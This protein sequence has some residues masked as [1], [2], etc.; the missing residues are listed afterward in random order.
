MPEAFMRT[1]ALILCFALVPLTLSACANIPGWNIGVP[2]QI[3]GRD[4]LD[5]QYAEFSK[6]AEVVRATRNQIIVRFHEESLFD[7]DQ[8]SLRP[9]AHLNLSQ[10]AQILI[11]YPGFLVVVAGHTDN[12]GQESHN[13]WIT[14]KRAYAVADF[15][16]AEGLD[17]ERIQVIGYGEAKPITT[18]ITAQG[19]QRNRRIELHIIR[20]PS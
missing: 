4:P 5:M 15:L 18:N 17:P 7:V 2:L 11:K 9:D 20:K 8:H 14:E 6:F 19:R 10:A 12:S 13:Q 16:V 1:T 3:P